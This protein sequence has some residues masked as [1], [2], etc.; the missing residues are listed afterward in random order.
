MTS[1]SGT[2]ALFLS[3]EKWSGSVYR[4]SCGA[5]EMQLCPSKKVK[6]LMITRKKVHKPHLAVSTTVKEKL[7]EVKF[8][9]Q[10]APLSPSKG[11]W[12]FSNLFCLPPTNSI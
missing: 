11:W 9:P 8:P 4:F 1:F 5:Q 2:S 12:K 10:K 3:A 6:I 7:D